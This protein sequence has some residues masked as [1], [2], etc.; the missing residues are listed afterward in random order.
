S[1]SQVMA[2]RHVMAPPAKKTKTDAP[3][4]VPL[5]FMTIE[6]PKSDIDQLFVRSSAMT[7]KGFPWTAGIL[8]GW[9]DCNEECVTIRVKNNKSDDSDCWFCN[10]KITLM[11]TNTDTA[12]N[13]FFQDNFFRFMP[14][15][16]EYFFQNVFVKN[17]LNADTGF[18]P[19][20][21][22]CLISIGIAVLSAHGDKFYKRIQIDWS[23]EMTGS[24]CCLIVGG[25]NFYVGKHM[26][27]RHTSYFDSMFYGSFKE[28]TM[29][30]IELHEIPKEDFELFLNYIHNFGVTMN[31]NTVW[32][33]LDIGH[34]FDAKVILREAEKFL[35]KAR[36]VDLSERLVLA[37]KFQMY[38]LKDHCLGQFTSLDHINRLRDSDHWTELTQDTKD[39]IVDKLFLF[40][41]LQNAAQNQ[42]YNNPLPPPPQQQQNLYNA[43]YQGPS[44]SS[45][46]APSY[47]NRPTYPPGFN[48]GPSTSYVPFSMPGSSQMYGMAPPGSMM[49]SGSMMPSG[50]MMQ[51][52]PSSSSMGPV[53]PYSGAPPPGFNQPTMPTLPIRKIA[54]RKGR[55]TKAAQ[56]AAQIAALANAN[57]HSSS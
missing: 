42:F 23:D 7:S 52:H 20:G 48:Q 32:G 24:D 10:A 31:E 1:W 15:T 36:D 57:L 56:A 25:K 21:G 11:I 2:T 47:N 27:V 22:P 46:I 13:I 40:T 37:D 35:M 30:R 44:T 53:P 41:K 14:E 55:P 39:I 16:T 12:K 34:R 8:S 28:A 19:N 49:G 29:E 51:Q 6:Y 18:F 38:A 45:F 17:D 5:E 43:G 26:L 3:V 9:N 4:S 54:V 50:S 33:L